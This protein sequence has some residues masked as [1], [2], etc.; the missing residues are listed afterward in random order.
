M[1]PNGLTENDDKYN[2]Y[3]VIDGV[4]EKVGDWEVSLEGYVTNDSLATT[5]SGYATTSN[6]NTTIAAAVAD[7]INQEQLNTA[8]NNYATLEKLNTELENKITNEDLNNALNGYATINIVNA[9][10]A[11]KATIEAL[12]AG[13]A[14]K[15]D[16]K[17]GYGLIPDDALAKLNNLPASANE[18]VIDTV[19]DTEFNLVNKHLSLKAIDAS[20]IL[21][22]GTANVIVSLN[23][24]ISAL[25]TKVE[26]NSSNI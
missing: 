17:N 9:A 5:L 6:V 10:V 7:K 8:L 20:K 13:L 11:D 16:V 23:N 14:K 26:T 22:L 1:V 25:N 15:V 24:T 21:N 18:N 12:N 4:I 2:E 3:M 19:E